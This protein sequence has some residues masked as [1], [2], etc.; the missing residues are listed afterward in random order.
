MK[1]T[2]FIVIF[3]TLVYL[4]VSTIMGQSELMGSYGSIFS[5]YNQQYFGYIS[6]VYILALLLPLY[7]FYKNTNFDFRKSEIVVASFLT[8]FSTL[9][10]QA[11]L[12]SNEFRGKIGADFVDFLSPY[13]GVFGLW[14]FWFII[15]LISVVM[16]LDRSIQELS[17]IV[18]EFIKS[19]LPKPSALHVEKKEV[20]K[21]AVKAEKRRVKPKT[22]AVKEDSLAEPTID[23]QELES[24]IDKPAYLRK[25]VDEEALHVEN[26]DEKK[27]PQNILDIASKVKCSFC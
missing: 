26:S 5:S 8:F 21:K 7:S 6:F 12:I 4:G 1:E 27:E 3:G 20:T 13:I 10:L 19:K 2:I 14:I 9:I 11:L 24:E 23:M 16:L 17:S 15:T 25:Q 22:D 18:I